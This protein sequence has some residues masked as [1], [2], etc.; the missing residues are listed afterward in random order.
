MWRNIAPAFRL[1]LLMTVLTGLIYPGVVTALCRVLFP[2]QAAGSLIRANGGVA[3]S[4]LIGQKFSRPE[5]FHPRPSAAGA[6]YDPLASGGSNLGPSNPKL[7]ER[8]K[9]DA[10]RYRIETGHVGAIPAD[11]VTASASGLDPHIT[12]LNAE[13][14]VSRVALA[15]G[16]SRTTVRSLIAA[17]TEGRTLGFLGEPR[18]NVLLL[19]SDLDRRHPV[20]S[21][22]RADEVPR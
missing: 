20:S 8:V 14:Q 17:H 11:A 15:R 3:G 1:M 9:A 2:R 6:G 12:P 18:V 21:T 10:E 5:Y 22:L 13:A 16:L 19:N 7:A 4:E